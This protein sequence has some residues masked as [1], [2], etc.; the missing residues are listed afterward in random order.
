MALRIRWSPSS[1]SDLEAICSFI[2]KGSTFYARIFGQ[3]ILRL[4]QGIPSFP[5]SGRIVPEYQRQDLREKIYKN[6]RIVYRIR[7]DAIEVVT[8]T[9]SAKPLPDNF[10]K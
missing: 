5:E 10:S 7:E 1:I 2:S 4:V 3:R 6:Y 8:I 9:H